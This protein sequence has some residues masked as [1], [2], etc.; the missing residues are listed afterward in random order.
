MDNNLQENILRKKISEVIKTL[1]ETPEVAPAEPIVKP[2][3]DEKQGPKPRRLGKPKIHPGADPAPKAEN[4]D[5]FKKKTIEEKIA[6]NIFKIAYKLSLIQE[7]PLNYKD[8]DLG[9]PSPNIKKNIEQR[10]MHPFSKIDILHKDAGNNQTSIE[11]IADDEFKDVAD[12]ARKH[13]VAN[14]KPMQLYRLFSEALV[15]QKQY[16]VELEHLAK[17]TVQKYF[18]IPSEVMANIEVTLTDNPKDVRLDKQD[19]NPP[20]DK[21]KEEEEKD[22][23]IGNDEKNNNEEQNDNPAF[24]E[25][26]QDFTPEEKIIIKQNV[27]KRTIANALMMGAGFRAHNLLEKIK[28][29]LDRMNPA[30]YLFYSKIMSGGVIQNWKANPRDD[31]GYEFNAKDAGMDNMPGMNIH[32]QN[33][34]KL[35]LTLDNLK[36]MGVVGSSRLKMGDDEN[37]DGIREVEGAEAIAMIFPV[38]LHETVKA[39]VEYIFAHGLPQYTQK[40]NREILKQSDGFQF[41][42]WHKLLGPR[43]WKYLHDAIDFIVKGRGNDYTIVAYLLQEISTLPPDKF[44]RLIDLLLHDGLKAITWLEK[45]LDRVESDLAAQDEDDEVPQADFNNIQN[46]MGQIQ[47]MLN[48]AEEKP[49]PEHK[50]FNQM[51]IQELKQ[52]ILNAL[53]A[54][55]YEEAAQAR[56]EI[57]KREQQ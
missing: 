42:Y 25:L 31:G 46:L 32:Q 23:N 56:D 13:G 55:D 33:N 45:M 10:R 30:L 48:V 12:T 16:T 3:P 11:K 15:A 9:E 6:E 7:A 51:D 20:P 24:D 52:F 27:D 36:E 4:N 14:M 39:V 47:G 28:P 21:N 29:E 44:L 26:V 19:N 5:V 34:H 49:Q 40:I 38:L 41:E 2:K 18:G 22:N 43:L 53:D 57:E 37:G 35:I 50:P 8:D 1:F 54:G 17:S